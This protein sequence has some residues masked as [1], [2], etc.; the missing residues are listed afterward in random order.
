M[1]AKDAF[2]DI[3]KTALIRDGWI[4]THDPYRIDLGFADVYIDFGA[5]RLIAADKGDVKIAVE[6]KTFL[7]PSVMA[8]FHVAIGQF[9]N[10]RIALEVEEEDR[11]MYL[12][13]PGDFYKRFFKY[14]FIQRV[15]EKNRIPLLV[16]DVQ[17]SEVVRWIK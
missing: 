7:S 2:Y 17:N 16:Y 6:V 14:E 13:I 15:I 12:G 11:V 4:V 10:Y 5:E 9:I 1:P 8:D 3:V